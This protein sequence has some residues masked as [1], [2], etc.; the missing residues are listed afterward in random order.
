MKTIYKV[1]LLIIFFLVIL[2]SG[3]RF[4]LTPIF[5][6]V[7]YR[8]P[9]F[10]PDLYGFSTDDRLH[11]AKISLDYL[12]GKVTD[13]EY[14]ALT[15]PNG[16]PLFNQRELSHMRDVRDLTLITLRVWRIGLGLL[17]LGIILAYWLKWDNEFLQAGRLAGMSVM[18]FI[19]VILL[20][21]VVSFNQLFTAFHR[22]F[23]EGDTWL[24]YM[25]DT[26]IRLFPTPFW[27]TVFVAIG[28]IS[29]L[30]AFILYR[31]AS[32]QMQH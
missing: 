10:P 29:F 2:L 7:E 6:E 23:F 27:V 21:V 26:L 31:V 28:L 14:E 13:A 16:D 19:A 4:C 1:L 9:G 30:L 3:I 32:R 18:A 8:I 12:L 20:A 11:Y 24:F 5:I 22:I 25:N 17:T 15:F